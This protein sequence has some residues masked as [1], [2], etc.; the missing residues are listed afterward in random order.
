MTDLA[1][2]EI[3]V[4]IT[5]KDLPK[6]FYCLKEN[7][8]GVIP[9]E[10]KGLCGCLLTGIKKGSNWTWTTDCNTCN[11]LVRP[12]LAECGCWLYGKKD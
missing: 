3:T 5:G 11:E 2:E 4:E 8:E 10:S 1:L 12:H 9:F 6:H 7:P